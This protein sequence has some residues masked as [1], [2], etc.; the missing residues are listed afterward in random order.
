MMVKRGHHWACHVLGAASPGY[1]V[2]KGST[3]G[4]DLGLKILHG[5]RT[6]LINNKMWV[7]YLYYHLFS[8][9]V[10]I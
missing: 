1:I 7:L 2:T 4:I 5:K 3:N 9:H 6:V 10:M 8:L